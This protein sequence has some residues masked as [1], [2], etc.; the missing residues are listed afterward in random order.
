MRDSR[1]ATTAQVWLAVL[2]CCCRRSIT[3]QPDRHRCELV[4]QQLATLAAGADTLHHHITAH[5]L[6]QRGA[7]ETHLTGKHHGTAARIH[8]SKHKPAAALLHAASYR[9]WRRPVVL[10]ARRQAQARAQLCE[11]LRCIRLPWLL[12]LMRAAHVAA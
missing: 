10:Q 9:R 2:G 6:R 8:L 5:L 3:Q 11:V 7:H 4:L 1:T 12:L